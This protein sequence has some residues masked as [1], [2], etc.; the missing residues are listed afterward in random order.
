M[1]R[2]L[3]ILVVTGLVLVLAAIAA[4]LA[5]L[6]DTRSFEEISIPA[7]GY[8][9]KGYF[10]LGTDPDGTWL[11]FTHGNRKAGQAHTLYQRLLNNLAAEI[12]ILAIDFRGY[13]QS[14]NEGLASADEILVRSGDIDAAVEYLKRTYDV[15]DDQIVLMGHS[16]G[17]LQVLKAAQGLTYR[18]VVAIGPGDFERFITSDRQMQDYIAKFRRN[19]GVEL[20]PDD[21]VREGSQLTPQALLSSC[22][23]SPI[24]IVFGDF[25]TNESL[26]RQYQQIPVGCIQSI[27][28]I[29]IPFSNHM[30]WTEGG[31]L[32]RPV[33]YF[34]STIA[35]SLLVRN[36]NHIL[37]GPAKS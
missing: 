22:P 32:P 27:K 11:I 36:L 9:I 19:T 3:L 15:R 20:T 29:T 4:P 6:S 25:E 1:K 18:L 2:W 10:S 12:S 14:S 24:T 13:G 23:E 26:Y 28:F 8:Q 33:R 34:Q 30:Y 5:Y 21:M 35:L 7:D 16:L 17:S 37:E 31:S